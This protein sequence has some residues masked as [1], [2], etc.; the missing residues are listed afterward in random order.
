VI[1]RGLTA[2]A[3]VG[4]LRDPTNQGWL[5]P[6]SRGPRWRFSPKREGGSSALPS[7]PLALQ[8]NLGIRLG[9]NARWENRRMAGPLLVMT[10]LL[11]ILLAAGIVYQWRGTKRD[12]ERQPPPGRLIDAG[13]G[14]RHIYILGSGNPPV[15]FESGV[16]ASSLNWRR[17]QAGV[18]EFTRACAY[19]RAGLGWSARRVGPTTAARAA[20]ELRDL[21]AAVGVA[22]PWVLVGH[23][24]GGYV[25][26]QL[27]LYHADEIG[28]LVL[29]D[30]ITPEDWCPPTSNQRYLI[31]GGRLFS[32]IGAVLASVGLVR[33][34]LARLQQGSG[35][36]GRTVLRRFG[37]TAS[38]TVERIVGEVTKLPAELWPAVQAHWSCPKSFVAMAAWIASVPASAR[39]LKE[40]FE[41]AERRSSGEGTLL[42][43]LPLVVIS[44]TH[45]GSSPRREHEALARLSRRGRV[46]LAVKGG[47]W[48]HL[49]DPDTVIQA[50]RETVETVRRAQPETTASPTAPA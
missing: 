5:R 3:T 42:G 32:Y 24:F 34:C 2:S 41:E 48:A 49:D 17:V 31:A 1:R 37:R 28:G 21:L 38:A 30:P 14:R 15:V 35:R 50:I 23:S 20:G 12:I 18:A 45:G 16:A 7:M 13:A 4:S 9:E 47:H 26:L 6:A 10:L 27:A 36:L 44:A 43:H 40:A 25:A 19:D 29:I 22:P 11:A 33:L 8:V 46:L 39:S